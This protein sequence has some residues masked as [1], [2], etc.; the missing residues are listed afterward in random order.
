MRNCGSMLCITQL[1]FTSKNHVSDYSH[2]PF[3]GSNTV[4][5]IHP[6]HRSTHALATHIGCDHHGRCH[7]LCGLRLWSKSCSLRALLPRHPLYTPT[8]VTESHYLVQDATITGNALCFT[9]NACWVSSLLVTWKEHTCL[10][11]LGA[12]YGR[13]NSFIRPHVLV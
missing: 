4:I 9:E 1:P 13:A 7:L 8:P 3:A 2:L 12:L 5:H 10:Y 6:P 11:G